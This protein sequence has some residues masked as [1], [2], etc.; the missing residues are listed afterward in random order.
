M[1]LLGFHSGKIAWK[2]GWLNFVL[3]LALVLSVGAVLLSSDGVWAQESARKIK[4][5]V[6]PEYPE[7]A[8]RLNIRGVVR[9][10]VTVSP[11]GTVK[12]I[13]E[14]GGNPVLVEALVRAVKKWKYEPAA[15]ESVVEVRFEF[16][17]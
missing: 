2:S 8:R 5:S 6:P 4:S 7:L 11:E 1:R 10:E 17:P 9:I 15:K 16:T 12:Q 14:L 3:A 13:K